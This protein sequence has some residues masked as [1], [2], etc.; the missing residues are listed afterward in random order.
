M[1]AAL[2]CVSL[3]VRAVFQRYICF[4]FCRHNPR[5]V[6]GNRAGRTLFLFGGLR[7]AYVAIWLRC[8]WKG[9]VRG[10]FVGDL[11]CRRLRFDSPGASQ[12]KRA[13]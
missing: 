3:V 8:I 1:D 11:G 7:P 12:N 5:V 13:G 6:T 10:N 2:L 4:Q 9:I